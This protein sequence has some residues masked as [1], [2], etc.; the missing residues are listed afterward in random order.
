[1]CNDE[2]KADANSL[3]ALRPLM[4][5]TVEKTFIYQSAEKMLPL[6]AMLVP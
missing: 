5:K 1:M 6:V 2:R 4:Q 3:L